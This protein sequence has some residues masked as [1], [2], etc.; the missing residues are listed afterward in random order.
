MHSEGVQWIKVGYQSTGFDAARTPL[1]TPNADLFRTIVDR[2][3]HHNLPVAV[4]H[5]WLHD[6]HTLLSFPFDTLEHIT[7][8]KDID[9][10]TLAKMAQRNLGVTSDLEQSAFAR[11]PARFLAIIRRG[12]APLLAKPRLHIMRL[13]N[14]VAQGRDIYGLRPRRKLMERAFIRE[15]LDRKM[16][17]LKKLSE[18]G[19]R[20][21]AG[22]D[23]GVHMFMG[24]LP[25]ELHRMCQAGLST[26]QV[27]RSATQE[28]ARL[29]G[30]DDMG[31]IAP[32]F[33]ADMVLYD[34][35]PLTD[36]QVLKEPRYVIRQGVPVVVPS[37][38]TLNTKL[39]R[40]D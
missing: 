17:N 15:V 8:D 18:Y 25:L 24:L 31:R 36:I 9:E 3:H 34:R 35:D 21:V 39:P 30:Y 40:S 11:E 27:L 32:G 29:L 22:T 5:Y 33:I 7:Q 38:V 12:T 16:R 6:L 23:A 1:M 4:H 20:V 37:L 26:A 10:A 2:A 13:L 19:I 14:D 28:A